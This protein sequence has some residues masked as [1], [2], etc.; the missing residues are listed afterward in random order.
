M[1]SMVGIYPTITRF[2]EIWAGSSL[3]GNM[4]LFF[5]GVLG[6]FSSAF[7]FS[8]LMVILVSHEFDMLGRFI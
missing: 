3:P 5:S 8:P 6:A 1:I 4:V 7:V 2:S